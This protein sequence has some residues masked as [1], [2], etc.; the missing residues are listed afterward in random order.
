MKIAVLTVRYLLIP[1]RVAIVKKISDN[2]GHG[3]C[4]E[5]ETL[6]HCW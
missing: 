1:V 2:K 4:G 3:G 5:K 6:V